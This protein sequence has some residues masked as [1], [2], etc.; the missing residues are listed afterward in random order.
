VFFA[1]ERMLVG[2]LEIFVVVLQLTYRWKES[3]VFLQRINS[4]RVKTQQEEH[5][6]ELGTIF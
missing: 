3:H 4:I 2:R 5:C 1:Y 6:D